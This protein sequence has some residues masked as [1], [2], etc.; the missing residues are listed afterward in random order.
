[1]LD[2]SKEA[3][4]SVT[5]QR[6]PASFPVCNHRRRRSSAAT[7]AGA[8]QT[9]GL[10]SGHGTLES[11]SEGGS[12]RDPI[13][14]LIQLQE[15]REKTRLPSGEVGRRTFE[16]SRQGEPEHV[17]SGRS[18]VAP[19]LSVRA[20][21]ASRVMFQSGKRP[22]LQP[23]RLHHRAGRCRLQPH[24]IWITRAQ[25]NSLPSPPAGAEIIPEPAI[26]VHAAPLRSR[27]PCARAPKSRTKKDSNSKN[28]PAYHI[29]AHLV[30]IL[31]LAARCCA[32][33]S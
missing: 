27:R 23:Q 9:P 14:R 29:G 18:W 31:K 21:T 1:V 4:Q 8:V 22:R 32:P 20:R 26:L 30:R 7:P 24:M 11:N 3:Q 2:R 6:M 15:C 13:E 10:T 19:T 28:Q 5:R 16:H 25:R 33:G 17:A 12:S